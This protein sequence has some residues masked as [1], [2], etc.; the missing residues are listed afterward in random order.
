MNV[1]RLSLIKLSLPMSS[2]LDPCSFLSLWYLC[3]GPWF[4]ALTLPDLSRVL[5]AVSPLRHKCF[6]PSVCPISQRVVEG[7]HLD[8]PAGLP[9]LSE[10]WPASLF[11]GCHFSS[12]QV[13]YSLDISASINLGFSSL[14][15]NCKRCICFRNLA[16]FLLHLY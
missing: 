11:S 15:I 5:S 2:C 16:N 9:G 1:G 4:S 7:N 14:P 6:C 3:A 10:T 8:S 13:L 12:H